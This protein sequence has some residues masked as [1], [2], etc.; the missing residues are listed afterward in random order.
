MTE[1]EFDKE[2]AARIEKIIYSYPISLAHWA[3]LITSCVPLLEILSGGTVVEFM[4][5]C[6]LMAREGWGPKCM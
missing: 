6:A 3:D 1:F 2:S 5:R 4:S